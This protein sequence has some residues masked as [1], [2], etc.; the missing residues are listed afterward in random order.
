MSHREEYEYEEYEPC[1]LQ[2]LYVSLS[3]FRIEKFT[4][5]VKLLI[6]IFFIKKTIEISLKKFKKIVVSMKIEK[7]AD[8]NY[9]IS[10][11][12]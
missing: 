6:E 3:Q 8:K 11:V 2:M 5:E 12:A 4:K 9:I 10:N 7:N 1:K